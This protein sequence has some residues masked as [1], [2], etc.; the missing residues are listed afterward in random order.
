MAVLE[1]ARTRQ[2][3]SGPSGRRR[4]PQRSTLARRSSSRLASPELL[5][6]SNCLSQPNRVTMGGPRS[7][8][9]PNGAACY[10]A[11][12]PSWSG[13]M[14]S[15]PRST[16]VA[17]SLSSRPATTAPWVLTGVRRIPFV[18]PERLLAGRSGTAA[19]NTGRLR[20]LCRPRPGLPR[21][22]PPK[23][24]PPSQRGKAPTTS[25]PLLSLAMRCHRTRHAERF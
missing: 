25:R 6:G 22:P 12:R 9:R 8:P 21:R 1:P 24:K 4:V 14:R 19:S 3:A 13:S 11:A 10:S 2:F 7:A 16:R 5:P 23:R 18:P 17:W 20:H 15:G